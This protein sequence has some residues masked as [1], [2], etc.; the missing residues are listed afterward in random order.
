MLQES[1]SLFSAS[2]YIRRSPYLARWE[3]SSS[4]SIAL[5]EQGPSSRPSS[6]GLPL[7]SRLDGRNAAIVGS[8][9]PRGGRARSRVDS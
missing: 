8:T 4:Y 7:G 1:L 5:G 3:R 2:P 9:C 6:R